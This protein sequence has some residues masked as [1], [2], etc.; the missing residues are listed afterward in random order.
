MAR[1]AVSMSILGLMSVAFTVSFVVMIYP[2]P[3][4]A[5]LGTVVV[6]ALIGS[7]AMIVVGTALHRL[8]AL[9]QPQ[10]VTAIVLATGTAGIA[11]A[12][13]P[14]AA[15]PTALAFVAGATILTGLLIFVAGRLRLG[16]LAR[17]IPYPV[18]GGFLAA[19]GYLLVMGGLS[20]ALDRH[21]A[22]WDLPGL[23]APGQLSL[24]AP[25]LGIAVVLAIATRARES[26]LILPLG[27][28]LSTGG[29]YLWL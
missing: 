21:V 23:L 16:A 1:T 14:E 11:A 26:D 12:A 28:L 19:T 2:A 24:W 25:W 4:S 6:L 22:L 15:G 27:I 18:L 9:S 8:P 17:V 3:I 29:F 13:A 5:M 10:E 7:A 20:V